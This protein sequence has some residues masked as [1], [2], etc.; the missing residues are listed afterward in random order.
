MTRGVAYEKGRGF[1]RGAGLRRS[2]RALRGVACGRG[3]ATKIRRGGGA[4]PP[5]SHAR[6]PPLG[7]PEAACTHRVV[8]G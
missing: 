2:L 1:L 6:A 3:G 4:T 5:A 8:D 7:V